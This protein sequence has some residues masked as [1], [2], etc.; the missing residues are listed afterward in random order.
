MKIFARFKREL[1]ACKQHRVSNANGGCAKECSGNC[2]T[3]AQTAKVVNALTIGTGEDAQKAR[4]LELT[5]I[6]WS[7][8]I[9]NNQ[10]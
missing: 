2:A 4:M 5:C 6:S 9:T 8:D 7:G 10:L 1:F 3:S